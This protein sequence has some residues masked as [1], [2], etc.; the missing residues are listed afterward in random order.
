VKEPIEVYF[1]SLLDA[2]PGRNFLKEYGENYET[3]QFLNETA[4]RLYI[5]FGINLPNIIRI[6]RRDE[7]PHI[8]EQWFIVGPIHPH[9]DVTLRSAGQLSLTTLA[10]CGPFEPWTIS[11]STASP[12]FRVLYPSPAIAV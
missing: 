9:E 10:A 2:E 3:V 7:L 1:E 6:V 8:T 11:N 12:S 4:M 5:E